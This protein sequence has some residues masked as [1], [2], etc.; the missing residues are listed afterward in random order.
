M[1]QMESRS[2]I[3]TVPEDILLDGSQYFDFWKKLGE[4]GFGGVFEAL[5]YESNQIIAVK[6]RDLKLG[7]W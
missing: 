1:E 3:N 4:G 2:S 5:D 7:N 6:V